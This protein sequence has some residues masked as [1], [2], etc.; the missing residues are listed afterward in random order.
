MGQRNGG[1]GGVVAGWKDRQQYYVHGIW[2]YGVGVWRRQQQQQRPLLVNG[3]S[4][5]PVCL[6]SAAAGGAGAAVCC[7][8]P[9]S[10]RKWKSATCKCVLAYLALLACAH[11]ETHTHSYTH[12][13]VPAG[14]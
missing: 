4:I 10:G 6:R 1:S 7:T 2:R 11:I 12:G 5:I 9:M 14:A 13:H 8:V 3:F